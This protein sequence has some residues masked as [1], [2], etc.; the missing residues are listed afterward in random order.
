MIGFRGILR[1]LPKGEEKGEGGENLFFKYV[2]SFTWDGHVDLPLSCS[3][4]P[5]PLLSLNAR[6]SQ[7]D[8]G[9]EP[10]P[11]VRV[12]PCSWRKGP[13][14]YERA[15]RRRERERTDKETEDVE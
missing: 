12:G 10:A 13:A 9:V 4:Y 3:P 1:H 7:D 2:P 11:G 5:Q 6:E 8:G 15:K 14:W